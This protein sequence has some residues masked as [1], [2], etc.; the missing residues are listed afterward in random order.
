MTF[1]DL[2]KQL[3]FPTMA[4]TLRIKQDAALLH[5]LLQHER[6][7]TAIN[8]RVA[9]AALISVGHGQTAERLTQDF[10]MIDLCYK[11]DI[12][13]LEAYMAQEGISLI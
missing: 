2:K 13:T 6:A 7:Q 3:H 11:E 4:G 1:Y 9:I 5:A 12:Q 10:K 8:M